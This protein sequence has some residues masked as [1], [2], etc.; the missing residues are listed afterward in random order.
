[1]KDRLGTAEWINK[2]LR[3]PTQNVF[4]RF[5]RQPYTGLSD[6]LEDSRKAWKRFEDL[7]NDNRLEEM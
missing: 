2:P 6:R 7:A 1:M 3:N 5:V 4:T